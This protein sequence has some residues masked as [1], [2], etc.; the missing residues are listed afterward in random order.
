MNKNRHRLVFSKTRGMLIAVEESGPAKAG[1]VALVSSIA[2]IGGFFSP[3]VV[4]WV[5]TETGN[6]YYG[7]SSIGV[8]AMVGAIVLIVGIPRRLI[9]S[10]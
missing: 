9:Q 10:R 1:G 7:L 6:L 8:I 2:A 5:K 4:G 3:T